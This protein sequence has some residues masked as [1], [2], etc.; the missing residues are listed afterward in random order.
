[1]KLPEAFCETVRREWGECEAEALFAAL[2]TPSP[3]AVRLH[4]EWGGEAPSSSPIP[5]SRWGYY[6][7]ERPSF[8]LDPAFH[9]GAYYVQEASSQFVGRLL[10]EE[11]IAGGRLLD[12]CAAPGGKT[13]LYA[14]LVG[15]DGLVV[16]NEVDRR[17][18]QTLQ[19]N[20]RKWGLGN[21]AVTTCEASRFESLEDWFDV[22]AVDAPCSGE[23]MFRRLRA[24][25]EEWSEPSV[26]QCAAIQREILRSAW[27]VLRPGGR[28]IYSTCTFNR[29]ENEEVLEDFLHYLREE[30]C[31]EPLEV[32]PVVE[33][34]SW[35]IV[36]GRVGAFRTYRFFPHRV[37]GEGFFAAVVRK[38]RAEQPSRGARKKGAKRGARPMIQRVERREEQELQRWVQ[39]PDEICFY[40]AGEGLYGLFKGGFE[41]V[42]ILS[43][44]VPVVYAGVAMGEIFKGNLKPDPALALFRG[45][46]RGVLP[47]A[48][49][50][51]EAALD[52]LRKGELQAEWFEPGMNLVTF[53]GMP[54]GFAKRIDN[55]VNNLYPNALRIMN[56]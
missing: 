43:E 16:A 10:A 3:T 53:E 45:L 44:R 52:Y 40:R 21:V 38:G 33:A 13:T 48:D 22:V 49:L 8:T 32:A 7:P 18:L 42:A 6:L 9:A 2:D 41:A 50:D 30:V 34:E 35:G 23:G 5:W 26:G 39:S 47:E 11:P 20:V 14:S 24:S 29:T 37:K 46:R 19:D 31:E 17:R 55:R 12:L 56:K 51:R 1:M 25:R 27:R 54:L 15:R 4:P 36:A 28:L